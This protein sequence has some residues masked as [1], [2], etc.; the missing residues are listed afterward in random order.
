M[1]NYYQ[2]DCRKLS[3]AERLSVK[4]VYRF[5]CHKLNRRPNVADMR[6]ALCFCKCRCCFLT[7]CILAGGFF[8]P[9]IWFSLI[10]VPFSVMA[11]REK[12][13]RFFPENSGDQPVKIEL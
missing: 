1:L 13:K 6:K 10:G 12:W 9:L 4:G 11:E 5:L 8:I 7:L 3:F 2:I